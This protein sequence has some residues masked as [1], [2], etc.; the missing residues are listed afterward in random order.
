MLWKNVLVIIGA[1]FSIVFCWTLIF[2]LI[3][4][5]MWIIGHRRAQAKLSALQ[6]GAVGQAELVDVSRDTSVTINGR[7]P[8]RLDY[9]FADAHG[10][11]HEG[12][13]HS[14]QASHSRRTPG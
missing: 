8:W 14:W 9:T 4:I 6:F 10:G 13:A 5:P 11:I 3:G 2:P 1:L 7:S 12:W